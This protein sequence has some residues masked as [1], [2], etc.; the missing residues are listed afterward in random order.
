VEFHGNDA[1]LVIDR[2]GWEVF[3]ETDR[4]GNS[5][6]HYRSMGLPRQEAGVENYHLLHVRNFL[7]CMRTRQ[8][9]HSDV[10]IGH[11]S[12]VACH[13]GNI[14]YRLGR[15]V[16][17][18]VEAERPINDPDAEKYMSREYRRPWTLKV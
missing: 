2:T 5:L 4:I 16:N 12:M 14:A 13:L 17:W 3:P 8:R 6:R 7:E 18:D 15:R 11:N 10:E 1:V 9:P